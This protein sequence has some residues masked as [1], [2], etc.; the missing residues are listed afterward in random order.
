MWLGVKTPDVFSAGNGAALRTPIL[1][2][3]GAPR[4]LVDLSSRLTHT[5]PR[6]LEGA[7]ALAGGIVGARVGVE[8]IPKSWRQK[9]HGTTPARPSL[10]TMAATHALA[11][12]VILVH[13]LRRLLPP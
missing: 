12:P 2:V 4:E 6:A 13:G 7:W 3:L 10:P 8:G 1:G 11:L 5:D 9:I